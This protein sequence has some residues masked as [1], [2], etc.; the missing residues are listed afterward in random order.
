MKTAKEFSKA[1]LFS[2]LNRKKYDRLYKELC[3]ELD[4]LCFEL[5]ECDELSG[6]MYEY[7]EQR[8]QDLVELEERE[9]SFQFIRDMPRKERIVYLAK[10]IYWRIRRML[11]YKPILVSKKKL[12]KMNHL[13]ELKKIVEKA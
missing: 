8:F 2:R 4:D 13:A 10:R 1:L 7:A 9:E 11:G 3:D 6:E 5:D 12:E